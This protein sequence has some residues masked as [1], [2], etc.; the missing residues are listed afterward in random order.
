MSRSANRLGRTGKH[1]NVEWC[2]ANRNRHSI[3]LTDIGYRAYT[4]SQ[5]AGKGSGEGRENRPR[6][7]HCNRLKS[8][9]PGYPPV[10][11]FAKLLAR[12]SCAGC[13][14]KLAGHFCFC[15]VAKKECL[16]I[17]GVRGFENQRSIYG[18]TYCGTSGNVLLRFRRCAI[19][20][21]SDRGLRSCEGIIPNSAR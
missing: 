5:F 4:H 20:R 16:V 6:S 15:N 17:R 2:R 1:K 13:P 3:R 19:V 21:E 7:R 9:K 12:R 11:R 18:H 14:T 8:R 10:P